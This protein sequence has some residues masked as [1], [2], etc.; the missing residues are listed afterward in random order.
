MIKP[1]HDQVSAFETLAVPIPLTGVAK[2]EGCANLAFTTG[3][4]HSCSMRVSPACQL[5]FLKSTL[6]SDSPLECEPGQSSQERR[7]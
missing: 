6:H 5:N 3:V 4:R 2:H 1:W 7:S